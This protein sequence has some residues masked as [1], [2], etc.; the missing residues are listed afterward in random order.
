M[1]LAALG[2]LYTWY[3]KKY[4]SK[5]LSEDQKAKLNQILEQ[6]NLTQNSSTKDISTAITRHL[7]SCVSYIDLYKT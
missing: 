3:R 2:L 6:N 7:K 4:K 1:I 5:S